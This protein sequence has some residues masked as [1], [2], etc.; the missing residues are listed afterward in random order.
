[1]SLADAPHAFTCLCLCSTELPPATCAVEPQEL[2]W[3]AS[4][5][6]NVGVDL[7]GSQ[8]YVAAV[9]ALQAALAAV[10]LGLRALAEADSPAQV[11]RPLLLSPVS[12][13]YP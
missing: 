12:L 8:Q 10:A 9:P 13:C 2:S 7:H 11:R 5:L 1:V 6:F 3:L 4:A